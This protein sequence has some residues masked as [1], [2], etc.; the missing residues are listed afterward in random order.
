MQRKVLPVLN[1]LVFVSDGASREVPDIDGL[2]HVWRNSTGIAVSCLPDCDGDTE[3]ILSTSEPPSDSGLVQ[4]FDGIIEVPSG[5]LIVEVLPDITVF[6][7]PIPDLEC[8][9][10]VWTDGLQDTK[11][12]FLLVS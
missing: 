10:R 12:V 11:V 6:R 2:S 8:R 7:V 4:I 3:V 9:I 1:S 5:R